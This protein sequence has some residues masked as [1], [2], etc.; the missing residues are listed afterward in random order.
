M[1]EQLIK[2]RIFVYGTLRVGMYNYDLYLKAHD[3]YV[4]D[5]YVKGQLH[6][7]QGVLYPALVKGNEMIIGEIHE[8]DNLALEAVDKMENY[9]GEGHI[10]NEYDKIL[11][12]ILDENKK[13]IE[14]LPVY[15]YNLRNEKNQS[16][17]GDIIKENDYV[18]YINKKNRQ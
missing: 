16:L 18:T 15:F 12:D 4:C 13:V 7:I 5:A 11:L 1:E 10:D 14:Q 3:T 6:T 2:T 8:V 9:Y 17:L